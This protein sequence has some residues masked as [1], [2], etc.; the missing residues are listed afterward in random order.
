MTRPCREI[1]AA[2]RCAAATPLHPSAVQCRA[3]PAPR[4]TLTGSPTHPTPPPQYTAPMLRLE[5]MLNSPANDSSDLA[6]LTSAAK[7]L[8]AR[9]A[10]EISSG[11]S[12]GTRSVAS[13][14]C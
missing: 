3:A 2:T 8:A 10:A 7:Q 1:R 6:F 13:S 12:R 4:A 14:A 9:N 5:E 11:L